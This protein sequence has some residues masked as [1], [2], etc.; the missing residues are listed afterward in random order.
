[1]KAVMILAM[2]YTVAF[3]L[4]FVIPAEPRGMPQWLE[5]TLCEMEEKF[6][7]MTNCK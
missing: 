3:I 6:N 7:S 2:I 5:I 1:M 4:R